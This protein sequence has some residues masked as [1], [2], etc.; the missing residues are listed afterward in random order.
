[1]KRYISIVEEIKINLKIGDQ[2]KHGKFKNK[3]ATVAKFDK[4]DKGE[5]IVI[6]DTGKAVKLLNIR[7]M[8]DE[9]EEE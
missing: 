6:T 1:M 5:D 3:V 7:L 2:F 4:N 8:I 9:K